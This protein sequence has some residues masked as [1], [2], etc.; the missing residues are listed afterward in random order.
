MVLEDDA[1]YCMKM[2]AEVIAVSWRC[3][4][5]HEDDASYC[6]KMMDEVIAVSWRCQLLHEDD[7]SY[8]MRMMAYPNRRFA[9]KRALDV[10]WV[11]DQPSNTHG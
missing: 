4:L 6:M 2:M 3:Q 1:S 9:V 10:F 8:C 5:L 7:A 11:E